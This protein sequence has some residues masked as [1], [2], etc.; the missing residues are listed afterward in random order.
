MGKRRG[1]AVDWITQRWVELTGRRLEVSAIPWLAGP[2]GSVHRIGADFFERWGEANGFSTRAPTPED[3]LLDGLEALRGPGFDPN[4]V[5]PLIDAFYS[6]TASFDLVITSRWSGPFRF[7]GWII[8]R[9]FARRLAQLNMPLSNHELTGGVGSRIVKLCDSNGEVCHTGWV[10]TALDTGHPVFVGR[11]AAGGAPGHAGP[12]V[13][14]T[15]P[16]PNGNAIILLRPRAIPG[17]GLQLI[18][19]GARFG[20]PGFYFTVNAGP[21]AVWTRYV[22]TMKEQ[23]TLHVEGDAIEGRHHFRVFGLEFLQLRYRIRPKAEALMDLAA[24]GDARRG[25]STEQV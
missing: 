13:Q 21:G 10:R 24:P 12:C 20:D 15:F 19:D 9:V 2:N 1:H 23:L 4:A 6:R 25:R 3:G 8:S 14:V 22:R 11:Y 7:L 18:S 16:L 5:H 17:G